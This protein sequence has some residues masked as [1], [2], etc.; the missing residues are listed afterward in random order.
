MI[1]PSH[2]IVMKNEPT[3]DENNIPEYVWEALYGA[4]C[5]LNFGFC[6][7]FERDEPIQIAAL[8][9]PAAPAGPGERWKLEAG[10]L[11]DIA[12]SAYFHQGD[13]TAA[14]PRFDFS[15]G[16]SDFVPYIVPWRLLRLVIPHGGETL[17]RDNV[18]ALLNLA[19]VG[20]AGEISEEENL[21]SVSVPPHSILARDD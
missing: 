7:P 16:L 17:A 2:L 20:L 18:L 21:V 19:I 3:G 14:A 6:K 11:R 1:R 13:I 8:N 12:M 9:A 5:E 10:E 15:K 4:N